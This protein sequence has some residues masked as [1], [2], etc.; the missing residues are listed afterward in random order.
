MQVVEDPLPGIAIT[1]IGHTFSEDRNESGFAC[2]Y[3][4]YDSKFEM[5]KGYFGGLLNHIYYRWYIKEF[6]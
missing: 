5:L 1:V 3:V 6:D 2:V 4:A